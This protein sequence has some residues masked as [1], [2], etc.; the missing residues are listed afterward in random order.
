MNKVIP[1][2]V[3]FSIF[4]SNTYANNG[5]K[6]RNNH[7]VQDRARVKA[8][9]S[10]CNQGKKETLKAIQQFRADRDSSRGGNKNHTFTLG[11]ICKLDEGSES[12][13]NNNDSIILRLAICPSSYIPE[14]CDESSKQKEMEFFLKNLNEACDCKSG[15]KCD[16]DDHLFYSYREDTPQPGKLKH[17][18]NCTSSMVT[19]QGTS[20][21]AC[22]HEDWM[23]TGNMADFLSGSNNSTINC[24][25]VPVNSSLVNCTT[26]TSNS[27]LPAAGQVPSL[28]TFLTLLTSLRG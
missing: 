6:Y 22:C 1:L 21:K 3:I 14:E 10:V 17:E 12:K 8:K 9:T 20:P 13:K 27:A 18:I 2:I 5:G 26:L 24:P 4:I 11:T 28:L 19:S 15:T 25:K 23:R 16:D 7:L